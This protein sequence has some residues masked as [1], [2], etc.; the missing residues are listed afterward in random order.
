MRNP[1]INQSP[2]SHV[3]LFGKITVRV[4][5]RPAASI[6][7]RGHESQVSV[8]DGMMRAAFRHPRFMPEAVSVAD[9]LSGILT[10]FGM[11]MDIQGSHGI[12]VGLG[13]GRHSILGRFVL[14]YRAFLRLERKHG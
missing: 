14:N 5:H 10:R 1:G 9:H 8:D 3:L 13:T 6:E 12:L 7:F 4:D 11:R 2:D